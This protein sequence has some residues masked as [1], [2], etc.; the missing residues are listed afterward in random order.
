MSIIKCLFWNSNDSV[1]KFMVSIVNIK[2]MRTTT[3]AE[4]VRQ[5]QSSFFYC[6]ADT[7]FPFE[8]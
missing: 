5:F 8:H 2:I 1:V 6:R 7:D 4:N 3:N